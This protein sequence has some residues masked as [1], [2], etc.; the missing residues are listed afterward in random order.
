[1]DG[2]GRPGADPINRREF[3]E[4][5]DDRRWEKLIKTWLADEH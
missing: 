4:T 2:L 1:L 3:M 5:T